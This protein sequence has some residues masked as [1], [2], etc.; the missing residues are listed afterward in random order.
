LS[1]NSKAKK[2]VSLKL[3]PGKLRQLESAMDDVE[4]HIGK[5]AGVWS[6]ATAEQQREVL[7][8]SPILSRFLVLAELVL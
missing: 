5:V 2:Q 4:E 7:E 1:P 3:T 8:R 6:L